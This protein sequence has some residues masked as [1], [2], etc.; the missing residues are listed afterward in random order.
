MRKKFITLLVLSFA[1]IVNAQSNFISFQC[2]TT[3]TIDGKKDFLEWANS[4]SVIINLD[5]TG[6]EIKVFFMK[7]Y[8]NLYVMY[9]GNLESR[10][11]FPELLIDAN[12][13]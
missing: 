2:S 11:R 7:D 5:A 3:P 1:L 9:A 13:S 6:E 8:S 10:F 4:D 12:N